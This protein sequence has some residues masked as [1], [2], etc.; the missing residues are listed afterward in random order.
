MNEPPEVGSLADE[1]RALAAALTDRSTDGFDGL[2]E[3]FNLLDRVGA[4]YLFAA[5]GLEV[6]H[7]L[8]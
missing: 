3:P 1:L 8:A 7:E 6:P 4:G 2:L 5:D